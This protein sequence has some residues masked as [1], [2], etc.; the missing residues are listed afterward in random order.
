MEY[1]FSNDH[2]NTLFPFFVHFDK[3]LNVIDTGLSLQK[4]LGNHSGK[5][6][7]EVFH[8]VRPRLSINSSYESFVEHRNVVVILEAKD[9]PIRIRFRGQFLPLEQDS[10]IMYICTPWLVDARELKLYNLNMND[11]ALHDPI[12]DQIQLIQAKD[13]VND[14]LKELTR[15]L[16]QQRDELSTK[17]ETIQEIAKFPE[18]N[19]HPILRIQY[20][21]T[22][23]YANPS[24]KKLIETEDLIDPEIWNETLGILREGNIEVPMKQLNIGNQVYQV[25]VVPF[26]EK[27]YFNCYLSNITETVISQ[28]EL[29]QT[30]NYL[31]SL[32]SNLQSG[33]LVESTDRKIVFT[34]KDFCNLFGVPLS[35]DEMKGMDCA[36]AA[37]DFAKFFKEPEAFVSRI[38]QILIDQKPVYGD[39]L[40]LTDGRVWE[41]DFIPIFDQN[42]IKGTIWRYQDITEL[43]RSKERYKRVEEKY[44][45]IIEKL[46]FGLVEVDNQEN[47]TKAFP[48]FAE[49]IGYSVEEL[50]GM[51]IRDLIADNE[52]LEKLNE[53]NELRKIGKS[54]V[55]ELQMT[56]KEGKPIWGIVSGTPIFDDEKEQIGSLGILV[57][58]TN[59]KHL[60]SALRE[61]NSKVLESMKAKEQFLANMS[62]EMRSPLNV[63]IG[64][65]EL[66]ELQALD[67]QQQ[68]YVRAV[69]HSSQHLLHLIND[70][71][72]Y[73][74]IEAGF[75]K[76]TP[77]IFNLNV[78][79]SD[80]I[81]DFEVRAKEKKL[82][83][84]HEI[85][86][87]I[88]VSI[89]GD[90]RK[91]T[92][93]LFNLISNAIKF[94]DTGKIELRIHVRDK[95]DDLVKIGFEITDTGIGMNNDFLK[96]I[97]KPF[98]QEDSSFSRSYG[99][100]GLGLAISKNIIEKCGGNLFVESQKNKGSKFSF[101]LSFPICYTSSKKSGTQSPSPDQF[102]SNLRILI[103]EDNVL[104]QQLIIALLEKANLD[105]VVVNDGI[106]ALKV[107]QKES[108]DLVLMDIQMPRMDG[109]TALR[110]IR[111]SL[112]LDIP[113]VALTANATK[114][115]QER[116][117][118]AGMNGYLSKPYKKD[119][120]FQLIRN[121]SAQPVEREKS[122][123][124]HFSIKTISELA[125]GDQSFIDSIVQSFIIETPVKLSAIEKG[126]ETKDAQAVAF[127]THQLKSMVDILE[128]YI[129]SD[130]VKQ[131]ERESKK[132]VNDWTLIES[133]YIDVKNTL[134]ET[135]EQ[136][137]RL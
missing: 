126:I 11:F 30:T 26:P 92:Q 125:G 6:F 110:H 29:I 60:E 118:N 43:I 90:S 127:Q 74:K 12:V 37:N 99:G 51:N 17:N 35:P 21:G 1:R 122:E 33:I 87:D 97:F 94:T 119:D 80:V 82:Q 64:M 39:I 95:S 108:F 69:Q 129:T 104:N 46:N 78:L 100:T 59:Q 18:Q 123:P 16:T 57:D 130:L 5:S 38:N 88:P 42:V 67:E 50:D 124:A 117:I 22:L 131:M 128:I 83:F 115:D 41:R 85:D 28:N 113:I 134:V 13:N 34:N 137:K 73:S 49:L 106:E 9:Y 54:G 136:L 70:V 24:A 7:D 62:H 63:I 48:S 45:G 47:I 56:S 55:Y 61:A 27:H 76:I 107:L 111:E 31:H 44:K 40:N 84:V 120:L 65:S 96:N 91:L 66:L 58:I 25:I 4:M 23:I 36:N 101:E 32:L 71:L 14:D 3:Q 15:I 75:L 93:V 114:E 77:V 52:S 10:G 81:N 53:Q 103:A 8:F 68:K 135:I 121:L 19:P 109:L 112:Q 79:V 89:L 2:L 133:L 116:F 72:D 132:E 105:H 102:N 98:I 86:P 20:D